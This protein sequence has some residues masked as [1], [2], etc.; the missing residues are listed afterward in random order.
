MTLQRVLRAFER[1]YRISSADFYRAHLR[2]EI[3]A[4]D[5]SPWHREIWSGTYRQWLRSRGGVDS[6]RMR[7]EEP[8]TSG[9]LASSP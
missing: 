1:N 5:L 9:E 4:A 2:N 7:P 6:L 3:P 8:A